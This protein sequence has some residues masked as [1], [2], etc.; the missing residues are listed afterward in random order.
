MASVT[1]Q[2]GVQKV[3]RH[4]R[5]IRTKLRQNHATVAKQLKS[6]DIIVHNSWAEATEK[7]KGRKEWVVTL[8]SKVEV[9]ILT[10]GVLVH[11][12]PINRVNV[13]DQAKT[14]EQ[15]KMENSC[16]I[17]GMDIKYVGWLTPKTIHNKRRLP[18]S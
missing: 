14:I 11:G 1:L 15:I 13:N 17:K 5:S 7:R 9:L 12:V 18:S 10:Y 8:G 4:E 2:P 3:C 6:G 16:I